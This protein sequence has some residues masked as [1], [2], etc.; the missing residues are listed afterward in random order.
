MIVTG[1][2]T[3]F[4]DYIRFIFE[5]IET[6]KRYYVSSNFNI[7]ADQIGNTF[8]LDLIE[9][10][11]SEFIQKDIKGNFK[12]ISEGTNDNGR[13]ITLFKNN[14]SEET[15][16]IY[17]NTTLSFNNK[18]LG[19]NFDINYILL[20][21]GL[22]VYADIPENTNQFL[23]K[24][25]I[26]QKITDNQYIGILENKERIFIVSQKIY[27]YNLG[28]YLLIYLL[29][30]VNANYFNP[31][32]NFLTPQIADFEFTGKIDS[33]V[34]FGNKL[35]KYCPLH[36]EKTAFIYQ[37]LNLSSNN[38]N[39]IFNFYY[40][41][42]IYVEVPSIQQT[43][44]PNDFQLINI[45]NVNNNTIYNNAFY[46]DQQIYCWFNATNNLNNLLGNNFNLEYYTM[47]YLIFSEVTDVVS[48]HSY[49][50]RAILIDDYFKFILVFTKNNEKYFVVERKFGFGDFQIGKSFNINII[51]LKYI[52]QP[53]DVINH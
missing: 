4:I 47:Y 38:I 9:K 18:I 12:L 48:N 10:A 33:D 7:N 37:Y 27:N 21:Y 36:K 29:Q 34:F 53:N 43:N 14:L 46:K 8:T 1:K 35:D 32:S 31:G 13:V 15:I 39:K 3:K 44:N 40:M 19:E 26:V 16:S 5:E 41:D 51:P 24:V 45:S 20:Y 11:S 30:M 2:I 25:L 42:I 50:L 23:T 17:L 6:K 28:Q 22:A 52:Y 49:E